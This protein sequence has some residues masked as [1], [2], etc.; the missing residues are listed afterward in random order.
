MAVV[1]ELGRYPLYI[2]IVVSMLNYWIRLH[3][4][5]INCLLKAALD[6]NNKMYNNGLHCWV[7]C[8]YYILKDFNML[9]VF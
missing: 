8:V 3:Y 6:E 7:S 2:D 4:S 5:K 9:N 1:G